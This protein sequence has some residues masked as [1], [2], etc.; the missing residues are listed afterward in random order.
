MKSPIV[1]TKFKVLKNHLLQA[2]GRSTSP[3]THLFHSFTLRTE[4]TMQANLPLS[5][6]ISSS[7]I[8]NLGSKREEKK[9]F[10]QN[11][12]KTMEHTTGAR[13]RSRVYH[14]ALRLRVASWL[15]HPLFFAFFYQFCIDLLN[16]SVVN[17]C[18]GI[19]IFFLGYFLLVTKIMKG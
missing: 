14:C 2:K 11:M 5:K 10:S 1:A 3:I 9:K 8:N 17:I 6:S 16:S 13:L 15:H 4:Q 7:T 18:F 12:E 19:W